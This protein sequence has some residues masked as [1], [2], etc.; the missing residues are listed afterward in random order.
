MCDPLPDPENERDL[1]TF[2]T[3]WKESKDKTL[4]ETAEQCQ[5]SEDVI[6]SMQNILGEALANYNH[7]KVRW[8]QEYM[9]EMRNIVISK[10]DAISAYILEYIENYTKIPPEEME[11]LKNTIGGRKNESNIRQE[12]YIINTT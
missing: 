4:K 11:K 9:K 6:R 3:L 7:D 10:Y 1:T 5:V 2:I 8:C 12:F